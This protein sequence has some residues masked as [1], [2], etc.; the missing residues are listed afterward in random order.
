[1]AT[2]KLFYRNKKRVIFLSLLLLGLGRTLP[3]QLDYAEENWLAAIKAVESNPASD[4][5]LQTAT[6][7]LNGF[8]KN[9]WAA[10]AEYMLGEIHFKRHEYRLALPFY[11]K[12]IARREALPFADSAE[13]RI[14][15]V[16]FNLG[17]KETAR[18]AWQA[19]LDHHPQ[20]PFRTE[21]ELRFCLLQL[22]TGKPEEAENGLR[23][24]TSRYPYY[25]ESPGVLT[26]Q[27]RIDFMRGRYTGV[28]GRLN[29]V[30]T[31]EAV[32]LKAKSL[33]ALKQFPEVI[34][35]FENN[36]I[37]QG[38]LQEHARVKT[39][40]LWDFFEN[41]QYENALTAAARILSD[42][43]FDPEVLDDAVLVQGL[44]YAQL[45]Q[46]KPALAG[47][48]H[49]LKNNSRKPEHIYIQFLKGLLWYGQ[50]EGKTAAKFW[51]NLL[52]D[53][54]P[55]PV[56]R[57][58]WLKVGDAY[59]AGNDYAKARG[60]YQG[61]IQRFPRDPLVSLAYRRL[62]QIFY[63]LGDDQQAMLAYKE[64]LLSSPA[65][66]KI[67]AAAGPNVLD[68]KIIVDELAQKVFRLNSAK[69]MEPYGKANVMSDSRVPSSPWLT[70]ITR[71]PVLDIQTQKRESDLKSWKFEVYNGNNN[72]V[73][74]QTG[75]DQLPERFIWTGQKTDGQWVEAGDRFYYSIQ[76]VNAMGKSL[77]TASEPRQL[78]AMLNKQEDRFEITL[79]SAIVFEEEL[80]T[81]L[82]VIGNSV[83]NECCDYMFQK[84]GNNIILIMETRDVEIG[85]AQAEVLQTQIINKLGV[86]KGVFKIN[87]KAASGSTGEKIKIKYGG[88]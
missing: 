20:S 14:G 32:F 83:M 55:D 35:Y 34:Q 11:E 27:A 52:A 70:I 2:I 16:Y 57:A 84:M 53:P 87:V 44:C 56:Y 39:G 45:K 29:Q 59:S 19:L 12:T 33:M 5:A 50:G 64:Y 41:S 65:G 66:K 67:E 75:S 49:W 23:E 81:R 47:Y 80:K 30:Y 48:D 25:R 73:F 1:M 88:L 69:A 21:I 78:N 38:D 79:R 26:G 24:L 42:P 61:F 22:Q 62:A 17:D 63:K 9:R 43:A 82:S 31:P 13:F 40:I 36:Y 28:L 74:Y 15:E 86:S 8:S 46:L 3:A 76:L 4:R 54:S 7:F 6:A 18:S 37:P 77:A 58:V 71:P 68:F 51:D 10:V 85:K 60:F 72:V